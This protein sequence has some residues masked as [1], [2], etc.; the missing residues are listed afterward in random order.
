V[1]AVTNLPLLTVK[2]YKL[3]PS[4]QN[5]RLKYSHL[6]QMSENKQIQSQLKECK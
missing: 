1:K 4:T 2:Q 3:L 5:N 6:L